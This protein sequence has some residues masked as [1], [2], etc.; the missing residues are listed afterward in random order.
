[1]KAKRHRLLDIV[2]IVLLA[3][4]FATV[5]SLVTYDP[6]DPVRPLAAPVNE[7]VHNLLN[8]PGAWVSDNSTIC[9]A[10]PSTPR[11]LSGS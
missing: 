6:H 9:L 5:A 4:W 7:H 1:M 8:L 10:G 3:G 11:W 2:G